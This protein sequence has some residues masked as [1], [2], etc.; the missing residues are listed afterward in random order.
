MGP[1]LRGVTRDKGPSTQ[2]SL[3]LQKLCETEFE[4]NFLLLLG[5]WIYFRVFW[6]WTAWEF[7]EEEWEKKYPWEPS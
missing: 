5:G 1:L 7:P 6:K 4:M 2:T 3:I